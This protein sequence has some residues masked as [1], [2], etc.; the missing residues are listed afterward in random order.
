M[1]LQECIMCSLERAQH[2][3]KDIRMKYLKFS[4]ILKVIR[5]LPQVV[6]KHAE[7]GT[8]TLERKY[9]YLKDTQMISSHVLSTMR[10]IL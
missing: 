10:V 2:Y 3:Y 4:S 6:I 7:F 9:K 5:L 8:Q 1:V